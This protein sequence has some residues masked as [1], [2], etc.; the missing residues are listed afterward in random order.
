MASIAVSRT[1]PGLF[2]ILLSAF[3]RLTFVD[4][5]VFDR[6]LLLQKG[7]K[8]VYFGGLGLNATTLIDYFER[9]GS[10]SCTYGEN[11]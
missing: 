3:H 5:Q 2:G 1:I 8:T 6:L 9:N 11:P 4:F 10:R 7:G